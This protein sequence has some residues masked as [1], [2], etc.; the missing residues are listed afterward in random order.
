MK[1]REKVPLR[2]IQWAKPRVFVAEGCF[3]IRNPLGGRT[4]GLHGGEKSWQNRGI[5]SEMG[6]DRDSVRDSGRNRAGA[7]GRENSDDGLVD[8]GEVFQRHENGPVAAAILE[9]AQTVDQHPLA[10]QFGR[11]VTDVFFHD[12]RLLTKQSIRRVSGAFFLRAM[13]D[14]LCG[15]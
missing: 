15:L 11:N 8:D 14:V 7:E 3:Q 1:S 10:C 2:G 13:K 6:F 9:S 12:F 4:D 5:G